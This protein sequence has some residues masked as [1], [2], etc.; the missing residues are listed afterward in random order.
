MPPVDVAIE[1]FDGG[2]VDMA[3]FVLSEPTYAV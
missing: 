1:T 2:I 3:G